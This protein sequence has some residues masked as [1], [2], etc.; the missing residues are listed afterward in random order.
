MFKVNNKDT[1]ETPLAFGKTFG[2]LVLKHWP[3]MG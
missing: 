2:F 3:E 1:T